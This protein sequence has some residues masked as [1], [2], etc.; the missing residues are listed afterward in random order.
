MIGR[1]LAAEERHAMMDGALQLGPV[2]VKQVLRSEPYSRSMAVS[3]K[4]ATREDL[5]SFEPCQVAL[6]FLSP[7]WMLA[8]VSP[9]ISSEKSIILT[10]TPHMVFCIRDQGRY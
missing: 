1:L 4:E 8:Y 10:V 3:Q 7:D 6:R 5:R 9:L 2:E